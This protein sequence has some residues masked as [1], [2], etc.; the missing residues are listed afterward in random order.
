MVQKVAI[1]IKTSFPF[2]GAASNMV[3]NLSYGLEKNNIEVFIYVIRNINENNKYGGKTLSNKIHYYYVNPVPFSNSFMK[4][5]TM[6]VISIL[7]LPAILSHIRFK[8]KAKNILLYDLDYPY[9]FLPILVTKYLLGI[10]VYNFIVD[11]YDDSKFKESIKDRIKKALYKTQLIHFNKL[12][13]GSITISNYLYNFYKNKINKHNLLI[14]NHFI[15]MEFFSIEKSIDLNPK[16]IKIGYFGTLS[17]L[18]GILELFEAFNDLSKEYCNIHLIIAGVVR[19]KIIQEEINKY[20]ENND[21]KRIHYLG[22]LPIEKVPYEMNK[23]EI[24]VNPRRKGRF[25]EAGFPTKIGEYF[26]TKIPTVTTSVG[27]L[28]LNIKHK[29]HALLCLPDDSKDLREKIEYLILYP[30]ERSRIAENAYQWARNNLEY[31]KNAYRLLM[32]IIRNNN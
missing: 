1:I 9:Y 2:G 6:W 28:K 22:N 29:E 23:C 21:I 20:E 24:L 16:I 26:S 18:N 19:D 32:F 7:S 25:S 30:A 31:N 27:D 13:D 12:Y 14:I 4:K 3:R 15:N 11:F 5:T 17:V 8:V 10:K